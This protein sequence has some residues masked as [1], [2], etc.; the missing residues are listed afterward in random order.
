M[1]RALAIASLLCAACLCGAW[2]ARTTIPAA[3]VA[4]QTISEDPLAPYGY[5]FDYS[6]YTNHGVLMPTATNGPTWRT[7]TRVGD[8]G[9]QYEFS[10]S[11]QYVDASTN[12]A[13]TLGSTFVLSYGL[14]FKADKVNDNDGLFNIGSFANNHG[15]HSMAVVANELR[16]H[17]NGFQRVA[18][19]F[20]DTNTWHHAFVTVDAT[21]TPQLRF[22]LD[23]GE[24][25]NSGSGGALP[26]AG[27]KTIIGGFYSSG[28]TFDGLLDDV[29][30]Y[31]ATLSS[32]QVSALYQGT[33]PTNSSVLWYK[34]NTP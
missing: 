19:A 29:R 2:T 23:G 12:V 10:G 5:V 4:T 6:S 20:T 31:K 8:S 13:N 22:Y 11:S 30:V 15:Y 14:W 24:V 17:A 18:V 1:K 32:N 16:I 9:G 7:A 3:L 33:S 25:G 27:S 21:A 26:L 28:Y 34:M